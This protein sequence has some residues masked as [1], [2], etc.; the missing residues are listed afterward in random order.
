MLKMGDRIQQFLGDESGEFDA[1]FMNRPGSQEHSPDLQQFEDSVFGG[2]S[3]RF[4]GRTPT[5]NAPAQ[6]SMFDR[7]KRTMAD[8][9]GSVP[10]KDGFTY[11]DDIVAPGSTEYGTPDAPGWRVLD[12]DNIWDSAVNSAKMEGIDPSKYNNSSDLVDA[13]GNQRDRTG[14]RDYIDDEIPPSPFSFS[15]RLLATLKDEQG[16]VPRQRK[17]R[18]TAAPDPQVIWDQLPDNVKRTFTEAGVTLDDIKGSTTKELSDY[19]DT[20]VRENAG[21]EP[22]VRTAPDKPRSRLVKPSGERVPLAAPETPQV[23][24]EVIPEAVPQL[25]DAP[26]PDDIGG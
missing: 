19:F 23:I 6:P 24:P 12:H 16:S 11:D 1:D 9:S 25:A 8:E 22:E 26:V 15:E 17:A 10:R 13:V 5:P 14:G 3:P 21:L 4:E 2:T 20:L 7:F 18:P